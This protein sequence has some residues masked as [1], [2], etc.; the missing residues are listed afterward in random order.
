ML[1]LRDTGQPRT[2]PTKPRETESGTQPLSTFL[3]CMGVKV[4]SEG[5]CQMAQGLRRKQ[6][7]GSQESKR[8]LLEMLS[9]NPNPER[10]V[11]VIHLIHGVCTLGGSDRNLQ[12]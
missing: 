1:L 12:L 8:S 10:G 4:G 5:A 11:G 6:S 9:F 2:E 3:N 7:D